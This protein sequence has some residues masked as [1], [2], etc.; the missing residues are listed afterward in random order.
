GLA[1]HARCAERALLLGRLD[2]PGPGLGL[3][4]RPQ[5]LGRSADRG[6][7]VDPHC[8]QP[9]AAPGRIT[10]PAP[11]PPTALPPSLGISPPLADPRDA[12]RRTLLAASAA[13]IAAVPTLTAA[14]PAPQHKPDSRNLLSAATFGA[15]GDGTT[16]DTAALQAA[17]D[18]AIGSSG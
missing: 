6:R 17:L 9:P 7:V 16:D 2:H 13:A 4:R 12:G 8:R 10:G 5:D 15:R 11:A 18:A 14:Q 3:L 1:A